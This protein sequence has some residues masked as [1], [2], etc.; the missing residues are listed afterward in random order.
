MRS[1]CI[2][3]MREPQEL[4]SKRLEKL[5]SFSPTGM[6]LHDAECI[7][8]LPPLVTIE[9]PSACRCHAA[10]SGFRQLKQLMSTADTNEHRNAGMIAA[11][12]AISFLGA[13]TS[14]QLCVPVL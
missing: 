3:L 11:S 14:T 1:T 8:F 10:H 5:V 2:A 7:V 6:L 4:C 12:I 9:E 13:F